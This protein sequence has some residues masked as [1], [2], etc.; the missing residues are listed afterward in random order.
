MAITLTV[1]A[2]VKVPA[3]PNF[4]RT[5]DG[6][7]LPLDAISDKDLRE[8]GEVWAGELIAKAQRL[9]AASPRP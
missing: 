3:V 1:T 4:L 7:T 6:Q 5:P 8:I 9:R 2:T